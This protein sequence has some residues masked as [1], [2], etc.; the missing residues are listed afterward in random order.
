[1]VPASRSIAM[2]RRGSAFAVL[3]LIGLLLAGCG[4]EEKAAEPV[5]PAYVV[6]PVASD[7]GV[8]TFPGAVRARYESAL[9]FRIGGKVAE[10]RVEVGDRVKAGQVL[11]RLDP[12]DVALQVAAT[13]AQL[14]AAE[15][16]LTLAAS[17]R[18]RY[19]EVRERGLISQSEF[20]ARDNAWKAAKARVEQLRAQ[21]S[22]TRNQAGYAEL[23]ADHDGVITALA[24]E[25]GQVVQPGQT[26]AVLAREDE[27]EVAISIPEQQ[28][29]RFAVGDAATVELWSQDNARVPGSIREIAPEADPVTRT[30]AAR[31]R[32][33]APQDAAL[34]QTARVY[35]V[36]NGNG[37]LAVPLSALHRKDDAPALWIYDPASGRVSLR[38]VQI[39]EYREATVPVRSGLSPGDWVVAAGVHLLQE[40]QR[41]TPIDRDNRRLALGGDAG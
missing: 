22:V 13:R 39:G 26:I 14:A 1:M 3:G 19:R 31:V 37:D 18:E 15:A 32:F 36:R 21:L 2:L 11:A 20:D 28:R 17:E 4:G 40:G 9:G 5:R 41:V 23:K 38:A 10:R 12:D 6:Q 16:D 24:V 27:V 8:E 29:A 7:A 25:V 33:D 30:H 35:F 34:G